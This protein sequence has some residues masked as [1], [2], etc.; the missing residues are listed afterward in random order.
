MMDCFYWASKK[1]RI[2]KCRGN[3]D[4]DKEDG[5]AQ[6]INVILF[7]IVVRI[8]NYLR[9]ENAEGYVLIAV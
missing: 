2:R 6:Y 7:L 3:D 1:Y 4:I 8:G 9:I 5:N